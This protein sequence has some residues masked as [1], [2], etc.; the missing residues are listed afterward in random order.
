MDRKI[1]EVRLYSS[2]FA[3]F[4][5]FS[6]YFHNLDISAYYHNALKVNTEDIKKKD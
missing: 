5:P 6:S 1:T 4:G 3:I 2:F